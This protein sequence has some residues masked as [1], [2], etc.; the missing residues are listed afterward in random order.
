MARSLVVA[1]EDHLS[2]RAHRTPSLR[3]LALRGDAAVVDAPPPSEGPIYVTVE[4]LRTLA[5]PPNNAREYVVTTESNLQRI[6]TLRGKGIGFVNIS[7]LE[8]AGSCATARVGGDSVVPKPDRSL[9]QCRCMETEVFL[10][11]GGLWVFRTNT[12]RLCAM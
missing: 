7:G 3:T 8:I 12:G 2:G 1:A 5:L 4:G 10:R 11:R 6:A 9:M